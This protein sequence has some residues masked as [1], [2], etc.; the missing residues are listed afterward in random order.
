MKPWRKSLTTLALSAAIAGGG[1]LGVEMF[2]DVQFAHAE[3]KVEA[4]R[5]Q[6]SKIEDLATVFKM[7]GK[8]VEPSV[9]NI[10]V[11]KTVHGNR[12]RLPFNDDQLRRWFPDRDGDGQ[13]DLPPGF[14]DEDD[15]ALVLGT[16]SGVIMEASDGTGYILTNNHVAGGAEDLTITLSDGRQI[17]NAKV[18]G[19]DPKSDLAVVKIEADHLI[20]AKWGDSGTLQ[21]GDWVLAFGSPFRYIG[22]MTH[23]IISALNRTNV[24]ILGAGGY[25]DFIQ[26]DAPINPGNSGGPLVNVHAEVI[27]INTAIASRS[28]GFQGIGFAIPSNQAKVVYEQ[29]KTKGKMERGWLGISIADV[30]N[31]RVEPVARNTFG[32]EGKTGVLVQDTF[33]GTPAYGKLQAGDI[34]TALNGKAVENVN[35][36]RNAIAATPAGTEISLEVFRDKKTQEVKLTV[37]AQPEDV[38]AAATG[39]GGSQGQANNP[40]NALGLEL[41][42]ITPE[43]AQRLGMTN[44]PESGAVVL[45]VDPKSP[46]AA[47]GVRPGDVITKVDNQPV[48]TADEAVAILNKADLKAGVTL[49]ITSREGSRFV[50]V[51]SEK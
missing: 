18:L 11:K 31:P 1:Y 29:L 13:P 23:G 7:V 17:T 26:T 42:T 16:G 27:G 40:G 8:A 19:A 36:L 5:E 50:F 44:P 6:L 2:R 12:P 32:Y 48:K 9:V 30:A 3:Q 37:G 43:L 41:N 49:Y 35:E 20:A 15:N 28:G 25:E 34:I 39:Q 46:A 45:S 4:T 47:E 38:M 10:D 21:Q 14:G 22:S 33:N 24:G 51:K